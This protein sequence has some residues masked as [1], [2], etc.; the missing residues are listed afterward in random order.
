MVWGE[1]ASINAISVLQKSFSQLGLT[2]GEGLP[3]QPKNNRL[4]ESEPLR[5]DFRHIDCMRCL[6]IAHYSDAPGSRLQSWAPRSRPTKQKSRL[7]DGFFALLAAHPFQT[8]AS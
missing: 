4:N 2:M 3:A 7:C 1:A 6:T 8:A 5:P